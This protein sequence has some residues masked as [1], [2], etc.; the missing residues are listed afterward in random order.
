MS[1]AIFIRDAPSQLPKALVLAKL[2][3]L[4][5]DPAVLKIGHNLKYDWVMFAKAGID[6]APFD[7]TMVMS[8]DLDAGRHGHG[9]DEL[10]KLHFDHECI[11][12][13]SV[14]GT[15]AK[16]ITFDKVPLPQ[17]TEYAAEDADI[18]LRLWLRLKP[19]AGRRRRRPGS[20]SG[21]TGR[22]SPVIGRMERRGVKV[23]RDYLAKLSGEFATEIAALEERDLRGGVRA[24]HDRLDRS[25]W[26]RCCTSGSAS[27]AGAR[28]RAA[29]IRPTSPSSSGWPAEGVEC[30]RLVLDWR[31]LTK[32]KIDLHRRAAGA[33]Q[34]RDRAGP[35]QLQPVG[36]ADRAA[37]VERPQF[38]EHPDPHRDRP[39][40]PRRL[41][42]RAGPCADERRL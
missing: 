10:A 1:A 2:K 3:P 37:V 42:R 34:P 4:L 40:D 28:A 7:D 16:Q 13:K 35:H 23:D 11:P 21:S 39:Q 14:C 18:T 12:F 22:W 41:R 6:V 15:G 9:M 24:V 36:R 8:F 29:H 25:N 27:R 30:A 32:L 38:A 26:A 33:D 17:A 5:E 31:Q 20:M 19:R